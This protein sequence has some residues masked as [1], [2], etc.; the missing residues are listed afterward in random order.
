MSRS[1][2]AARD[3]F[4]LIELLVALSVVAVMAAMMA[5]VFTQMRSVARLREQ[6]IVKAELEGALS[7]LERTLAAAKPAKLPDNKEEENRM[8]DGR[9][10][11]MRF[12]AVTRQGFYSLAFRDIDIHIDTQG[13][14]PRLV[15]TMSLRRPPEVAEETKS[16]IIILDRFDAIDFSYSED[17]NSF[18]SSFTKDGIIPRMVKVRISRTVSGKTVTATGVARIL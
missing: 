11:Q 3:G 17:G 14:A 16:T 10:A 12:A 15:Q 7:H 8:F 18:V 6:V 5:G 1:P 2:S 4:V 9:A 13:P